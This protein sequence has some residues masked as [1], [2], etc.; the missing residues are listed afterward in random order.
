MSGSKTQNK[1]LVLTSKPLSFAVDGNALTLN[2]LHNG[3]IVFFQIVGEKE[4]SLEARG[5]ATIRMSKEQ[6]EQLSSLITS[7]L[8]DN[9]KKVQAMHDAQANSKKK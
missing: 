5:V 2:E 8:E 1:K 6:L 9:K 3:E 7:S 4:G